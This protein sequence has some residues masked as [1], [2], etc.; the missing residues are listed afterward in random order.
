MAQATEPAYIRERLLPSGEIRVISPRTRLELA[1][2]PATHPEDLPDLVRRACAAQREWMG[3]PLLQRARTLKK[4]IP[5]FADAAEELVNRLTQ[6]IGRDPSESWFAEIIPNLDLIRY[7]CG[8]GVRHLLPQSVPLDPINYPLKR[9]WIHRIPRGV[10]GLITPWN[11][12]VSIPLRGL[13]PALLAGNA[14]IWKPSEYAAWVSQRVAEIFWRVLPSDLLILAQGGPRVGARLVEE[15]DALGFTGSLT[16]GREIAQRAGA[17]MIPISLE[18]GGKDLAIVCADAPIKRAAAGIAWGAL[19]NAGQNCAAI[20]ILCVDEKIKHPF[21]SQLREEIQKIAGFV[22]PLIHEG[23][24]E[25]VLKQ[26]EEAMEAGAL[27]LEGGPPP[28][29]SLRL[30]PTLLD[31]VPRNISLLTEETFGPVLPVLTFRRFE[32]VE[33]L[34]A[35][36]KYGLTLSIWTRNAKAMARWALGKPVGVVTINNH[37]FTAAVPSLPWSGVRGSG[38][39]VTNSPYALEWLTRPQV[40]LLDRHPGR[41]LWWHPYTPHALELARGMTRLKGGRFSFAALMEVLRGLINR[42]R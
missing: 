20:E 41:E 37:A 34:L 2:I 28:P 10:V 42:W 33:E 16:V 3:I 21:L 17:R 4:L 6:E 39:G 31:H 1:R 25:R 14:V 22:G 12:P 40:L 36:Q 18:L 8:K 7:W 24:L 27:V 5:I 11:Y 26:V 19:T 13:I 15:V 32:E 38:L 29:Q 30:P 9:A 23:Q 35:S